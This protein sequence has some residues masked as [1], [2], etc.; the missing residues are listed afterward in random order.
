MVVLLTM[1][2]DRA[3]DCGLNAI[4]SPLATSIVAVSSPMPST[5][6]TVPSADWIT[7]MLVPSAPKRPMESLAQSGFVSSDDESSAPK[8]Q[9]V[10]P[11]TSDDE[12][13]SSKE[14]KGNSQLQK[15]YD[16]ENVQ[17][18]SKMELSL[19]RRQQRKQRNRISAAVSRQKQKSRIVELEEELSEWKDKVQAVQQ[20]LQAF[21]EKTFSS[22]SSVQQQET[23]PPDAEVL[24]EVVASEF[25]P[26]DP[27]LFGSSVLPSSVVSLQ[28]QKPFKMISRQAL[29]RLIKF[30]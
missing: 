11:P 28:N 1:K 25:I 5:A 29:S 30:T 24:Q 9:K 12:S 13:C 22:I 14:R 16:P 3:V 7:P 2:S 23:P 10:S 20:Q 26:Q 6:M 17:A 15:K 18:M 27:V 4:G 19:W 8:K 21:Q